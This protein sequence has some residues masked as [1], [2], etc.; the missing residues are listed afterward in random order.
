MEELE[1]ALEKALEEA[2]QDYE[3]RKKRL[4]MNLETLYSNLDMDPSIPKAW[5]EWIKVA[6]AFIKEKEI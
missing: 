2:H 3:E 4:L 6:I 1:K 5:I